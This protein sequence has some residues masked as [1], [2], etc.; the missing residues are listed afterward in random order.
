MTV[1]LGC[2]RRIRDQCL[3]KK[4]RRRFGYGNG[5]TEVTELKGKKADVRFNLPKSREVLGRWILIKF[6]FGVD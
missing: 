2:V 3:V 4:G 6:F 1:S 5:E